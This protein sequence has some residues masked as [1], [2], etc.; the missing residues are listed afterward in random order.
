MTFRIAYKAKN[1]RVVRV[2]AASPPSSNVSSPLRAA[3]LTVEPT[4]HS[5]ML[6]YQL[7]L[8]CIT[9]ITADAQRSELT[10]D[11]APSA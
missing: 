7:G 10:E 5:R 1:F 11:S 6:P 4:Q 8:V 3:R 9:C 2:I